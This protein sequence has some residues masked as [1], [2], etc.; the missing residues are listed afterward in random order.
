MTPQALDDRRVCAFGVGEHFVVPEPQNPVALTLQKTASLSLLRRQPVMPATV[1]FDDQTRLAANKNRR[2]NAPTAPA[3]G[4]CAPRSELIA[5]SAKRVFRRPSC[6]VVRRAHACAPQVLDAF[7]VAT[8][9]AGPSPP[10]KPSPIE[11]EGLPSHFTPRVSFA[12]ERSRRHLVPL[13]ASARV[14]RLPD[15]Y[16]VRGQDARGPKINRG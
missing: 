10:L 9:A 8:P 7:S 16:P 3:A 6:S 13:P 1:D 11:G 2:Y 12:G 5:G 15:L 14:I 4:T